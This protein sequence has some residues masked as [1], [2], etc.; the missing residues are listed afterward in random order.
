MTRPA[1]E[2][3]REIEARANAALPGPWELVFN[4]VP[5][6]NFTTGEPQGTCPDPTSL[7]ILD[8]ENRLLARIDADP[9]QVMRAEDM[10]FI[11]HARE[12]IPWLLD[13]LAVVKKERDE[14]LAWKQAVI[15]HGLCMHNVPLN[16]R[17]GRCDADFER[18]Y[19]AALA[20]PSSEP[21]EEES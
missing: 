4:R 12:D 21:A 1:S 8:G 18:D 6:K 5:A 9:E 19:P 2:H 15:E 13:A 17:C 16:E 11:A 10:S 20:V 7:R 14:L 3:A